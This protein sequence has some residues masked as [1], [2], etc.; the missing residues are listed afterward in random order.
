MGDQ[1]EM[2]G[3]EVHASQYSD[4]PQW[5]FQL[6]ELVLFSDS[7]YTA[8]SGAAPSI[9]VRRISGARGPGDAAS[10]SMYLGLNL[11]DVCQMKA[12]NLLIARSFSSHQDLKRD[13]E[14]AA[15][16]ES[17]K[18]HSGLAGVQSVLPLHDDGNGLKC[19]IYQTV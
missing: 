17:E 16:R 9:A 7:A 2:D 10:I 12:C 18:D 3:Y 5:G 19:E 14:Q 1:I 6:Q 11:C 8:N 13:A 4:L 15:D